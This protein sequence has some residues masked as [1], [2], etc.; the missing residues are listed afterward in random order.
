MENAKFKKI[1]VFVDRLIYYYTDITQ[2][3]G[4]YQNPSIFTLSL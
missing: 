4:S 3:D 1:V 2:R